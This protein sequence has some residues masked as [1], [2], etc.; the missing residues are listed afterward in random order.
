MNTNTGFSQVARDIIDLAE[1]QMQLLSVDSQEAKRKAVKA[2]AFTGIGATLAGSALTT[3]MVGG[4]FLLHELADW[5]VGSSLLTIA[6]ATLAL[7]AILLFAA[8]RAVNT[9]AA[10][11]NET[12][13]EFAENLKW[14]KAVIVA[15]ET[16][17][18]NQIR[19]EH[20]PPSTGRREPNSTESNNTGRGGPESC[21]TGLDS[22][23]SND[24]KYPPR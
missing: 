14:I 8:V 4:G 18:R 6:G 16:S 1:L 15:P 24:P 19:A 11:M 22:R 12:K 10:A 13:S 9:A 17:P 20:F 3:A 7:V 23:F 5:T 2:V 21:S